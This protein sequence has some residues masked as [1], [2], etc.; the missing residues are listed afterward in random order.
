M[1]ATLNAEAREKLGSRSSRK[2]RAAGRIPASIQGESRENVHCTLDEHEFSTARRHH[3]HL[4]EVRLGEA[5]EAVVVRELQYDAFGD[6]I[7]H[8]EFRRVV[9]GREIETEVDLH[10]EGHPKGGV[11]TPLHTHVTIRSVPAKIPDAIEVSVEGLEPGHPLLARDLV[12]PEGASLAMDP[13]TQ[14]A[15]VSVPKVV[16][17]EAPEVAVEPEAAPKAPEAQD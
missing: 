6:R 8:V 5:T 14:I 13:K 12:L 10:F 4:F 17:E 2:L 15:V 7:I 11:L 9:L 3:Q 16:R 1:S